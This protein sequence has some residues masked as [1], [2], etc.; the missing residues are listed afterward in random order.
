MKWHF[1]GCMTPNHVFNNPRQGWAHK[2][3]SFIVY[4]HVLKAS[5]WNGSKKQKVVVFFTVSCPAP[6]TSLPVVV[7]TNQN[8]HTLFYINFFLLLELRAVLL[9]TQINLHNIVGRFCCCT[10]YVL[11]NYHSLAFSSVYI[12]PMYISFP[13]K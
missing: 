8:Y 10:R 4:L 2:L 7:W 12:S 3:K 1:R 6:T 9:L 11:I 5:E 13:Q